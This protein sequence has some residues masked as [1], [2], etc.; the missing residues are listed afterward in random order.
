MVVNWAIV[1][2]ALLISSLLLFSVV[3][4]LDFLP[5]QVEHVQ[6]KV[7]ASTKISNC[8]RIVTAR[9]MQRIN[10]RVIVILHILSL[11]SKRE[12]NR[13][14]RSPRGKGGGVSTVVCQ[15]VQFP[16]SVLR[17]YN[18]A[19]RSTR[20]WRIRPE[21]QAISRWSNGER[22]IEECGE[23]GTNGSDKESE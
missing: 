21:I 5:R 6:R 15:F 20:R 19:S 17:P 3:F 11:C 14:W 2:K 12:Q 23:S 9:N 10:K 8:A 22:T 4:I 13:C 18:S 1:R 16:I 7:T